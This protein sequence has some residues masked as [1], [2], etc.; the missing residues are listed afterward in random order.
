MSCLTSSVELMARKSTVVGGSPGDAPAA[1]LDIVPITS[2]RLAD[3]DALLARGDPRTCQCAWMRLTNA[4]YERLS[5]DE[6]RAVHHAAIRTAEAE[7][8][9]A[10]LLAYRQ[11]VAVGWVSFD[12]R[13]EFRRVA[14][15]AVRRAVDDSPAWSVVCFVV[16]ARSRRIGVAARLL[17]SAVRSCAGAGAPALEAYPTAS[18][19]SGN[20]L[21][22]GTVGMFERAGFTRVAVRSRMASVDRPVMRRSLP[23]PSSAPAGTRRSRRPTSAR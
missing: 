18:G 17:D 7:G 21:W 12:R 6:R 16:A 8:R 22:R 19:R 13:E 14:A 23:A 20:D 4:E 9:A 10:G 2:D 1:R 5:P 15:S 11:D 3:L